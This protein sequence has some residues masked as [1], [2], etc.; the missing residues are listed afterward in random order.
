M[1]G[2]GGR[3]LVRATETGVDAMPNTPVVYP[4]GV[5][6]DCLEKVANRWQQESR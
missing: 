2:P 3:W 6:G 1:G 5:R 4:L